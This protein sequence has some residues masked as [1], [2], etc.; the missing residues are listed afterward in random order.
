MFRAKKITIF[1]RTSPFQMKKNYYANS[2][3]VDLPIRTNDSI[4]LIKQALTVLKS[5]YK[6]EYRYQKAGIILS[7]LEDVNSYNKN[8]FSKIRHSVDIM[9]T[10]CLIKCT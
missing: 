9:S 7:G 6:K 10:Q 1:I 2:K 8:L 4:I 5:I 3:D